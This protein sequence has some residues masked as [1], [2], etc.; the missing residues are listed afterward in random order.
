VES[1]SRVRR[2]LLVAAA[3]VALQAFALGVA[4]VGLAVYQILGHRPHDPLDAWFVV[5]LAAVA[6][7]G[8]GAVTR[9]LV[10][11]RRW[12][13]AP[14]VFTQIIAIPIGVN[15]VHD[16]GWALVAGVVVIA[17]GAVVLVGLFAPSTTKA[18]IDG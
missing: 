1:A 9:G 12:S 2:P 16:N 3:G 5:A 4:A 10:R 14:A 13:R 17:V 6:A 15:T 8:L 18:L 7:A 11:R